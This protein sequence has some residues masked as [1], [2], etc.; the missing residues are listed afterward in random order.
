MSQQVFQALYYDKVMSAIEDVSHHLI[1]TFG[2]KG[3]SYY[4]RARNLWLV[5]YNFKRA[6]V[7]NSSIK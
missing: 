7:I 4:K 6:R 1:K 5:N 2:L 3:R